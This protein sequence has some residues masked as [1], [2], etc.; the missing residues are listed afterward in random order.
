[1][2]QNDFA[3]LGPRQK[4]VVTTDAFPDRKYDGYIDEVSPEANRQKATVQVK[5]K[6]LRPDEYLRPDMNASVAFISDAKPVAKGEIAKPSVVVP[7]SA[8]RGGA[9][10]VMASGRAV[11]RTVKTGA[12]STMS[13]GAQ[14]VHIEEGLIGGE[15]LIVNPPA[16]LKDGDKVKQK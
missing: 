12:T 7:I 6:I 5:V 13:G 3:K 14:G 9:V 16:D 4:G 8:V 2:N 10:F 1:V 11:K 15:D